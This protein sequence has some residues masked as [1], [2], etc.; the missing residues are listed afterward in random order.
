[1]TESE[2]KHYNAIPILI[3]FAKAMQHFPIAEVREAATK[4]L[5]EWDKKRS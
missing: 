1:M 3:E 4:T 2:L 5:E